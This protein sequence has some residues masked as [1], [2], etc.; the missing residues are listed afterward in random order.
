MLY[1]YNWFWLC[2]GA[3]PICTPSHQFPMLSRNSPASL[4]IDETVHWFETAD[5]LET[6]WLTEL[7]ATVKQ[8]IWLTDAESGSLGQ[9]QTFTQAV[10]RSVSRCYLWRYC[11][12]GLCNRGFH[13]NPNTNQPSSSTDLIPHTLFRDANKLNYFF[14]M[15]LVCECL[16]SSLHKTY[17]SCWMLSLTL[18]QQNQTKAFVYNTRANKII[19]VVIQPS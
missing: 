16:C 4:C 19:K 3:V 14:Q 2:M 15:N 8:S 11:W 5:W 1:S 18:R 10:H 17:Y 7:L 12:K 9:S 6:R 13:H